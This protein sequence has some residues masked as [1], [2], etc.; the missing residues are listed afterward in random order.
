MSKTLEDLFAKAE[1]IANKKID[2]HLTLRTYAGT[3]YVV[4][5]CLTHLI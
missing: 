4:V 2:G 1:S 3:L 5:L